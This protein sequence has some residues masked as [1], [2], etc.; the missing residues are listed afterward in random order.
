ML[1]EE[2]EESG[3]IPENVRFVSAQPLITGLEDY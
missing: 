3:Q 2:I 1:E